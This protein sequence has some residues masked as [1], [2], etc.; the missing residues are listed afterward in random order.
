RES[1]FRIRHSGWSEGIE[2]KGIILFPAPCDPLC[3][4]QFM[5]YRQSCLSVLARR[6]ATLPGP[7][8]SPDG[9]QRGGPRR[10]HPRV[11]RVRL[12][13]RNKGNRHQWGRDFTAWYSG[14]AQTA[15]S[16]G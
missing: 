10:P 5:P 8:V 16:S 11:A 9:P 15:S 1:K 7:L 3:T 13:T 2:W 4:L 14:G 12:S 6:A